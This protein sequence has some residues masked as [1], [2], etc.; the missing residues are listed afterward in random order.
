MFTLTLVP[1]LKIYYIGI[2][3]KPC[4]TLLHQTFKKISGIDSIFLGRFS[5]NVG[6][7]PS[8]YPHLYR[9]VFKAVGLIGNR[10]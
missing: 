4:L 8:T 7:R 3:R 1:F 2:R 9:S 6:T 5:V 10:N